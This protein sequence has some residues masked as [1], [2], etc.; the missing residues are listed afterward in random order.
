TAGASL[1]AHPPAAPQPRT[2][3]D[4]RCR[5]AAPGLSVQLSEAGLSRARGE[6]EV[7]WL[8]ALTARSLFGSAPLSE[9]DKDRLRALY[10]D[11]GQA[12]IDWL[13]EKE[14]VTRHDVKAV[15]YLVRDRLQA[16]GL[17]AIAEL[18]HFA[19]TSEDVNSASYALTVKRAVENVW[20]PK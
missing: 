17:D 6:V 12:D 9:S 19:C 8:T 11:F 10:R 3:R 18:T 13:A 5:A 20:L 15:E 1:S 4:G 14:A 7:E 2:P 16:L